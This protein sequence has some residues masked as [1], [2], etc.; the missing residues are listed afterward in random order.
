MIK[1][2]S[3]KICSNYRYESKGKKLANSNFY[4]D[5]RGADGLTSRC[6][7]CLGKTTSRRNTKSGTLRAR[8][9]AQ[10]RTLTSLTS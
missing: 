5:E 4:E 9:E 10:G 7:K 1:G 3:M 2:G 6:K 8:M